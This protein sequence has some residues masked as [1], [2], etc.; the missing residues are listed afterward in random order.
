M[1]RRDLL[2]GF[3]AAAGPLGL[4]AQRRSGRIKITEVR[5]LALRTVRHVG[6]LEPAWNKGGT[7]TF[8]VGGGS[9]LELQTDQ[10]L[11]SIGPGIDPALL[12]AVRAQ[13]VGQDPFDTERHAARLRYYASGAAYRG[14]GCV[15]IALWDLIGKACGQPLYKLFGGGKDSVIP[16]ASMIALGTSEERARLA[17][18]LA[19]EGW[20]ANQAPP[21]P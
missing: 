20:R 7:M 19:D 5:L 14:S 10:G 12:E 3:A 6:A 4:L 18:S 15:D 9:L 8:T 21:A 1:T 13:L 2:G 17:A 16:Y 11:S